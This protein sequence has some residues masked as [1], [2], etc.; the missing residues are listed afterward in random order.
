M[1][2]K[3]PTG[4]RLIWNL[5]A[6]VFHWALAGSFL[7]AC[8][9]ATAT[10]MPPA[11]WAIYALLALAAGTAVTGWLT[12]NEVGGDAFEDAHETLASARLVMIVVHH[13]TTR[14]RLASLRPPVRAGC[15]ARR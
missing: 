4:R 13:S 2:S 6:R 11:G 5:P 9:P 3:N 12:Y 14:V 10:V 8:L 7:G 1:Q 15:S